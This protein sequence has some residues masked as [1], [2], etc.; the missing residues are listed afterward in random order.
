MTLEEALGRI[1]AV[2]RT[3]EA[4][5]GSPNSWPPSVLHSQYG[6]PVPPLQGRLGRRYL[7]AVAKAA[8][9]P[10]RL[11][12]DG[13]WLIFAPRPI[14]RQPEPGPVSGPQEVPQMIDE[15]RKP[16]PTVVGLDAARMGVG[17]PSAGAAPASG[18]VLEFQVEAQKVDLAA[19]T[20]RAILSPADRDSKL[21]HSIRLGS[22]II[23]AYALAR[24]VLGERAVSES[25]RR[26]AEQLEVS[27]LAL[28]RPE[29]PAEGPRTLPQL[30]AAERASRHLSF[31]DWADLLRV[32]QATVRRWE[33]GA[34]QPGFEDL[35]RLVQ[36]GVDPAVLLGV[37]A[38]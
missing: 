16:A 4:E 26:I 11:E 14:S 18:E 1:A 7:S 10:G 29:L 30:L 20:I 5:H 3:V 8:G 35:Q 24:E 38:R 25:T 28:S 31:E 37:L 33:G 19:A 27:L 12:F 21:D 9:L 34:T 13:H 22:L 23:A 17:V 15:N 32:H 36:I 6:A 2:L